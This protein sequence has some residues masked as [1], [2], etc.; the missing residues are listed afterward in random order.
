MPN[1]QSIIQTSNRNKLVKTQNSSDLNNR[2]NCRNKGECPLLGECQESNIIYQAKVQAKDSEETYIGL[3]ATT[4]K[5]RFSNH[6]Q[7]FN[8]RSK[9]FSTQLSKYIWEQKDQGKDFNISWRIVSKARPYNNTT[10]RCHLC[11]T[12]KHFIINKP[13]MA[14]LNK[15]SELI[16]KCR[17]MDKYLVDKI[18]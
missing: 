11:L 17:H 18:S 5:K 1:V 8:D 12:E 3:T 16:S 7:S 15:R 2:C 6:K 4:F 14:T 9:R 10:K 13:A